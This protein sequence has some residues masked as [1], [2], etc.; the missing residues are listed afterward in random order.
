[1]NERWT[2]FNLDG[3][4]RGLTVL[5]SEIIAARRAGVSWHPGM[6]EQFGTQC[7]HRNMMQIR[8][9]AE[10]RLAVIDYA[11]QHG[12]DETALQLSMCKNPPV[13]R[14]A[15]AR[16]SEVIDTGLTT[17]QFG[18]ELEV[19][20]NKTRRQVCDLLQAAGVQCYVGY[21]D[22]P[23]RGAW[24]I[25]TDNSVRASDQQL[26][27]GY[28]Y[29]M[30][31]V[32]P[33]LSGDRGLAEVKKVTDALRGVATANK[34]CGMH[35]HVDAAG[36][37]VDQMK[38]LSAAWLD[39]EGA[40]NQLIP[41]SRRQNSFCL[42]NG[43]YASRYRVRAAT[44]VMGL[45]DE[46]QNSRYYKFNLHAYDRHRTVEFRYHHGTANGEKV[47]RQIQFCLAF[48]EHHIDAGTATEIYPD[49]AHGQLM[50]IAAALPRQLQAGFT[51]YWDRCRQRRVA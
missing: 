34:T 47:T 25:G 2:Y 7:S 26:A 45:Q 5:P 12:L 38:K 33:P 51:A 29:E 39:N 20:S 9:S 48:V 44:T 21:Y 17:R 6:R 14:T 23:I 8:E 4:Q 42:N 35:V 10:W 11:Q 27:R 19:V 43:A 18:I 40:V 24:K 30:E 3:R 31:I 1:M 15:G 36:I 32:S 37:N 13:A 16:A 49:D 46:M 41:A 22:T 50:Q 28:H